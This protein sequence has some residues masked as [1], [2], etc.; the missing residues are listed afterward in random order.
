MAGRYTEGLLPPSVPGL[1]LKGTLLAHNGCQDSVA[2]A[3]EAHGGFETVRRELREW[4]YDDADRILSWGP[5]QAVAVEACFPEL[6]RWVRALWTP[7][8][9][10]PDAEAP[11]VLA[12]DPTY[13]RDAGACPVRPGAGQPQTVA[14]D[15]GPGLASR[16]AL[17]PAHHLPPDRRRPGAD[18][19]AGRR[20]G[21]ALCYSA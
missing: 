4:T 7:C 10:A 18:P 3:L 19:G 20:S 13:H 1:W 2:L 8:R 21:H 14:A 15:C 17:S 16:P 5:D 12:L 6:L 11:L 9:D